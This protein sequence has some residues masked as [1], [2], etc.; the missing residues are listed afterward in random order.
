MIRAIVTFGYVGL[1]PK[2]PGTWGSAAAVPLAW[3]VHWAGGGWAMLAATVVITLLGVWASRAYLQGREA[4]P[5]EVV[6]D[7]VAGMMVALLPFS[8]ALGMVGAEPHVFPWPGW[9]GGF[10]MFRIFDILKPPPIRWLDRPTPWGIML[11][12]VAA[13]ALAAAVMLIAAGVSHGWF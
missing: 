4:D 3:L 6:I 5:S 12:D 13:G 1:L 10:V 8:F 2:A 9:V 11:D 7:E